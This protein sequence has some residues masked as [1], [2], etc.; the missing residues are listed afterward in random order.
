MSL[1]SL[2][3]SIGSP[4]GPVVKNSPSKKGILGSNPCQGTKVPNSVATESAGHNY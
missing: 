3:T 1:I 2:K 4:G